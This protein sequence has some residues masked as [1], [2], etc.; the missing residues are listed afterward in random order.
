ML[1]AGNMVR[2]PAMTQ[3]AADFRAWGLPPPYRVVGELTN[4]DRVM[5]RA[6]WVGVY[7][8][9]TVQMRSFVV[10]E[11]VKFVRTST[12]LPLVASP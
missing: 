10:D 3:R 1:F 9:L 8:G 5:N 6:F 11:M 4:S 2:Q 12:R 7:P